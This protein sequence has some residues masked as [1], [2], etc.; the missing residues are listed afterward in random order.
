[1]RTYFE[2]LIGS[3]RNENE[4][5]AAVFNADSDTVMIVADGMGGHNGGKRASSLACEV[6]KNRMS[7]EY[8]SSM[9]SSEAEMLMRECFNEANATIWHYSV[10]ERENRGMGT[11]IVM[12]LIRKDE[13]IMLNIGDSRA[14]SIGDNIHQITVDQSYVQSLIE[15]GE[16][17]AE[18][19]KNYPGKSIIMQAVGVGDRINP[20]VYRGKCEYA[21]ILCSDGLTNEIDDEKIFEIVKNTPEKDAVAALANSANENGG[22]DN[23]TVA[24]AFFNLEQSTDALGG[25]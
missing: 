3:V 4:D 16:I 23:I 11:T 9:S 13:Y 24:A 19:A 18:E 17:T 8:K 21:L 6:I 1:M 15:R 12:A 7:D 14:Y 2:S 5:S 10:K 22:A 20:D 25:F